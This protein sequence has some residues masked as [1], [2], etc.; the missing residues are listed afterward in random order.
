MQ[1]FSP[2]FTVLLM[3]TVAGMRLLLPLRRRPPLLRK[4]QHLFMHRRQRYKLCRHP[5]QQQ[6]HKRPN[7]PQCQ[8]RQL[9]M[10]PQC[11]CQ[12]LQHQLNRAPGLQASESRGVRIPIWW[13]KWAQVTVCVLLATRTCVLMAP[14]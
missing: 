11:L 5:P 4:M 12:Q 7:Q 1:L 6:R 3:L 10:Q 8:R 14:M 13:L 2:L 9:Q